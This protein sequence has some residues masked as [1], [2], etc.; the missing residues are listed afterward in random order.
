MVDEYDLMAFAYDISENIQ[1]A[2]DKANGKVEVP[3][4]KNREPIEGK[5]TDE[6]SEPATETSEDE[7]S[8]NNTG[9]IILGVIDLA[10]GGV[11]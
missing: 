1:T 6:N 7:A 9:L 8:E 4:D 2:M 5:P 3:N 11:F 10:S